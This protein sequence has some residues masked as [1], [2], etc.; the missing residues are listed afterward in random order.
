MSYFTYETF[1]SL[2]QIPETDQS[3]CREFS[4][5]ERV[6]N[7]VMLRI[8]RSFDRLSEIDRLRA[9]E[10]VFDVAARQNDTGFFAEIVFSPDELAALATIP[11]PSPNVITLELFKAFIGSDELIDDAALGGLTSATDDLLRFCIDMAEDHVAKMLG[12]TLADFD[13]IPAAIRGAIL[14]LAAHFYANREAVT[15]GSV[16]YEIPY[17]VADMLRPHRVEVTGYVRP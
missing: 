15:I 6:E 17:G 4:V 7:A 2:R 11:S 12:K 3:Y 1:F 14:Q 9:R 10:I 13:P 16:G 8:S 5:L